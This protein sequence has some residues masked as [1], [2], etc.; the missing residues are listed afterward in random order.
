MR[1][2]KKPMRDAKIAMALFGSFLKSLVWSVRIRT[3][4]RAGYP[5]AWAMEAAVAIPTVDERVHQ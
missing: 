2:T 3:R 1:N 5:I 4:L